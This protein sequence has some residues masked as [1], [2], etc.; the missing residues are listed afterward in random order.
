MFAGFVFLNNIGWHRGVFLKLLGKWKERSSRASYGNVT[1]FNFQRLLRIHFA[2]RI[3]ILF[4]QILCR[5]LNNMETDEVMVVYDRYPF[6]QASS[7][8]QG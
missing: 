7:E 4:S 6:L 1:A 3:N 8:L 5:V 2:G